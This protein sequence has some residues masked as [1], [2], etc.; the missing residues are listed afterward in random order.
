MT[1]QSLTI[2]SDMYPSLRAMSSIQTDATIQERMEAA[3]MCKE[4]EACSEFWKMEY[5]AE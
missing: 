4:A 3:G 1:Q 5:L 2:L